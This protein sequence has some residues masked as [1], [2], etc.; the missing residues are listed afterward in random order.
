MV[1]KTEDRR[2]KRKGAKTQRRKGVLL[3]GFGRPPAPFGSAARSAQ[4]SAS[5]LASPFAS[6]SASGFAR[7][8]RTG[9]EAVLLAW[10]G[11]K[12]EESPAVREAC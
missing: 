4:G 2:Q 3:G 9:L 5:K 8:W 1:E 7:R 12:V 11:V 10:T 6:L